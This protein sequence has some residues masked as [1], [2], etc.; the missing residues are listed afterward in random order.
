MIAFRVK[1]KLPKN[2][3]QAR[4]HAV[5]FD[6][7]HVV[8]EKITSRPLRKLAERMVR[9]PVGLH[10]GRSAIVER[11]GVVVEGSLAELVTATKRLTEHRDV[12]KLLFANRFPLDV[13]FQT[14]GEFRG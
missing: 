13:R 4:V 7:L 6:F 12:E 8:T 14:C 9:T 3:Y 10:A 11:G 1:S 2:K 5:G